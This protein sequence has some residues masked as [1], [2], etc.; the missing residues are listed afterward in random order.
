VRGT[1]IVGKGASSLGG[2]RV[3]G[4]VVKGL[5]LKIYGSLEG[6]CLPL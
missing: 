4:C 2:G 6:I 3:L 1:S 5:Y